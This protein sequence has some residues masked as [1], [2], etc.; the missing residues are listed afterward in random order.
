MSTILQKTRDKAKKEESA[1]TQIVRTSYTSHPVSIPDN[2]LAP[3]ADPSSITVS[4]IDFANTELPEYKDLYA[5]VL[6]NV[7]SPQECEKLIHLAEQS[8]GAHGDDET[9]ENNGWK[10]AMVNAGFN[11]EFLALDYRNSDRIIWDNEVIVQRLWERIVEA[12]GIKEH[13]SVL[14]GEKYLPVLGE[15]AVRRGDR[16][17]VSRKG[18]NERMRFMKY[19]AGQFFRPHCDGMYESPDG[20][21]RSFYTLHLYLNDSAQALGIEEPK[22]EGKAGLADEMLRGGATTFHS[23]DELRRLDVDPKAGRVLIFQQKKIFHSG[24][25]VTAGIKYTM[26]SDLMY[27]F[28]NEDEGDGDIT[29]A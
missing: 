21:Q 8:A 20:K 12:E 16:W 29:F 7:M 3:F 1:V 11:K 6:D 4:K 22:P 28:E 25:D 19:G 17:V 24:D 2:F 15:R 13:L 27:E 9:V 10:P 14:E 23:Y 18:P 26:R 5:V